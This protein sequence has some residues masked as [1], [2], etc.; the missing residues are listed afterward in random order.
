MNSNQK[1]QN[2]SKRKKK[3]NK[4]NEPVNSYARYTGIAIQMV[5]IIVVM[6]LAG[7]KLDSRRASDTPVFTLIL[8]L[9]GVFAAIYT[10]IKDFIKK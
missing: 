6:T 4:S 10:A 9:L 2:Q 8:S 1:Q 3:S 5:A 7:V